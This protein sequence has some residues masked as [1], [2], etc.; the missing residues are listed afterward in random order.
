MS[1]K[2][3]GF[4]RWLWKRIKYEV[5]FPESSEN[6]TVQEYLARKKA[7]V[8]RKNFFSPSPDEISALLQLSIDVRNDESLTMRERD[9]LL[10]VIAWPSWFPVER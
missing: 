9:A 8:T 10:E 7:I 2:V 6:M 3:I 1:N 4:L 5:N